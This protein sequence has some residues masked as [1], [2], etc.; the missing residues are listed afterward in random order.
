M[1]YQSLWGVANVL[2]RKTFLPIKL[3]LNTVGDIPLRPGGG[4]SLCS[5]PVGLMNLVHS[6]FQT[7]LHLSTIFIF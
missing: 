4:D 1:T 3:V 2:I 7:A 6:I 5:Y